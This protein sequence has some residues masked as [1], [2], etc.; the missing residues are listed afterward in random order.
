MLDDNDDIH[1]LFSGAPKSTEFKKLRKR[2]VQ[3]VRE[4]VD[5]YGM[6]EP[7][8]RWLVCLSGG[9]DSYTLLAALTE[10]Q[11]RGLLPVEI[12]ACNLDQG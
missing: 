6:I 4:A 11:W 3:E 7:G 12:L 2:I 9:K 8:A 10:L 1:P 5:Q